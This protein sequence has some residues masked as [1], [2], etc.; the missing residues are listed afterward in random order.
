MSLLKRIEKNQQQQANQ[1]PGP[2]TPAAGGGSGSEQSR[3]TEM[4]MRRA[5][6]AGAPARD[7]YLDLK[8]RVQN[9]LL[10]EM[11]PALDVTKTDEVRATIES[12][13]DTVLADE[14]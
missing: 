14:N 3:L 8:T 4:R 12:L 2:T 11:D 5:P 13:Y 10:A 6:A 9:K 7:A 1:A